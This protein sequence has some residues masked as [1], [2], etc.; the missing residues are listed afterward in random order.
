MMLAAAL[1]A[2][3]QNQ[4]M[5]IVLHDGAGMSVQEVATDMKVPEGTVKSWLSR[6]RADAAAKLAGSSHGRNGH[7]D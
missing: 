3:P 7:A 1:R 5:A 4:M 6:G 2:L